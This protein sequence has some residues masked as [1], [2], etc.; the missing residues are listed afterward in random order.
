[1]PISLDFLEIPVMYAL[2][3]PIKQKFAVTFKAGPY[4]AVGLSGKT[5]VKTGD[6]IIQLCVLTY[7]S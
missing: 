6:G 4:A 3:I 7:E 1:M 2:R 5:K